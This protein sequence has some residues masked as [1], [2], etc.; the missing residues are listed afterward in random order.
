R[1]GIEEAITLD[2]LEER[3]VAG[4]A[5]SALLSPVAALSA[6]PSAHLKGEDAERAR[7]GV[8]VRARASDEEKYLDGQWVS[9][10]G[11][12]GDLIAVALY[13]AESRSLRP[14][15]VFAPEK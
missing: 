10:I 8:A 14:R 2:E 1:L 12:E 5:E 4:D 3:A 15:V 13:Q 7:H 6:L 11:E 9:M